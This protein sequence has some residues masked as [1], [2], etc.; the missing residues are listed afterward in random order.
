MMTSTKEKKNEFLSILLQTIFQK[1]RHVTSSKK[2]TRPLTSAAAAEGYTGPAAATAEICTGPAAAVA[3]IYDIRTAASAKIYTGHA[4]A[5]D[6]YRTRR[7]RRDIY[8]TRAS[9]LWSLVPASWWRDR[10]FR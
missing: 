8:R 9:Y 5:A 7:R 4:A 3:E 2:S 1:G 10:R 6:I